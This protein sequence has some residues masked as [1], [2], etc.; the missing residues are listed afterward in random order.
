MLKKKL[1]EERTIEVI[2]AKTV[3]TGPKQI[4]KIDLNPKK[5]EATKADKPTAAK[6]NN[7]VSKE[8]TVVAENTSDKPAET[9]KKAVEKTKAKTDDPSVQ[10]QEFNADGTPIEVRLDTQYTKLSGA[11]FTGQTID[12]SQF[13]KPKKK[14]EEIKK[15][16][17][18]G[19]AVSKPGTPGT[20][21]S[22][23]NK[24]KRIVKPGTPNTGG[25]TGNT[26]GGGQGGFV[27]RPYQGGQGGQG[28]G[29]FKKPGFNKSTPIVK[30]EPTEEERRG[31]TVSI[32]KARPGLKGVAHGATAKS[33]STS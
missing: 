10:P 28:G 2:K 12:L 19:A 16:G 33:A 22:A 14:K 25:T 1:E 20:P 32:D 18:P 26:Q 21:G 8:K 31:S 15:P 24:R 5:Q 29:G 3:V 17:T 4:G 7:V 9:T 27:K 13:N 11:T 23:A 6:E 30:V